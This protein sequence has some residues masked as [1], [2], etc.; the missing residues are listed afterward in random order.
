MRS[1]ININNRQRLLPV[2]ALRERFGGAIDGLRVGCWDWRS[3]PTPTTFGAFAGHD[4]HPV[5]RR[6]NRQRIRPGGDGHGPSQ[7]A[8]VRTVGGQRA[9][10]RQPGAGD[11]PGHGV[12]AV[13]RRQLAGRRPLHEPAAVRVR[14][15]KRAG[16]RKDATPGLPVRGRGQK[17]HGLGQTQAV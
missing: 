11:R 14:R 8:G 13:R 1:V 10:G 6:G 12:V 4:Q 7:P 17:R 15:S 5:R 2:Y 16:R 3:S 9:G